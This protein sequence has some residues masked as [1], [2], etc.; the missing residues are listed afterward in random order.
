MPEGGAILGVSSHWQC[1]L[2]HSIWDS[3]ENG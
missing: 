1:I 2:Q 3:Y